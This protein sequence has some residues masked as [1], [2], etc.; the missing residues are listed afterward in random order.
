MPLRDLF[1]VSLD[2][3]PSDLTL[4]WPSDCYLFVI[5]LLAIVTI[6]CLWHNFSFSDQVHKRKSTSISNWI[7]LIFS[8]AVKYVVFCT[9]C[10]WRTNC[11]NTKTGHKPK[12]LSGGRV[13]SCLLYSVSACNPFF[14]L[15]ALSSSYLTDQN[16]QTCLFCI[17]GE[18]IRINAIILNC[19]SHTPSGS[20]CIL[21][22]LVKIVLP[23]YLNS[24]FSRWWHTKRGVSMKQRHL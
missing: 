9:H 24:G 23:L 12:Y 3:W 10:N 7:P 1:N 11:L 14:V 22:K 19:T 2:K 13:L 18:I 16:P 21:N 5:H 20:I 8:W 6:A 15:S 17:K 4:S